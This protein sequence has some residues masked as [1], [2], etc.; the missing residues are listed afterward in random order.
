MPAEVVS[1]EEMLRRLIAFDTTSHLSNMALI[2]YVREYLEGHGVASHLSFDDDG[3]KANLLATIGPNVEGG[4][5]LSG[6]TDV[7]PVEGQP[8]DTDPFTLT[9][10]D[11]KLFARGTCD[12]KGFIAIALA[13]VPEFKA[14]ATKRPIHFAFTYDEEVGCYGVQRLIP[15]SSSCCP[16]PARHRRRANGDEGRQRPQGRPFLRHHGDRQGRPFEPA[17]DRLQRHRVRAEIVR[18]I[19]AMAHELRDNADPACLFVP[20]YTTFNIGTITGGTAGNI[21]PASAASAGTS[22]SC[23]PTT[24]PRSRRASTISSPTRSCRGC[25]AS[26]RA[27]RSRRRA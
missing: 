24:R 11:G 22:G 8:W 20:P 6:H 3:K 14:K 27:P 17:A 16:S 12:M 7:V 1:S 21:I 9:E 5:V 23:R 2:D 19:Y 26:S 4:Y 13:M 18:F 15:S 10:R 25:A